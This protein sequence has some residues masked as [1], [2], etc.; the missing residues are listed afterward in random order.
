MAAWY[1][2]ISGAGVM[3]SANRRS[4]TS[5]NGYRMWRSLKM[6]NNGVALNGVCNMYVCGNGKHV[7]ASANIARMWQRK[8]QAWRNVK[9]NVAWRDRV[10]A[11]HYQCAPGSAGAH[12]M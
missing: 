5:L 10:M 6:T 4:V 7:M 8:R 11:K 9:T 2:I 3:S 1:R 12:R